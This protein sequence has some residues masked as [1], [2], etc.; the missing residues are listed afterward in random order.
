MKAR[1]RYEADAVPETRTIAAGEFK[2]KCLRLMDEVK[3]KKLTL[4]IT[5]RGKPIMQASAPIANAVT[6]RPLWGRSP[7]VRI[8]GDIMQPAEWADPV[9]KWTRVNGNPGGKRK[10]AK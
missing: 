6:F 10:K 9:Q 5:K 4:I 2:A 1:K 8:V 3:E 7:S